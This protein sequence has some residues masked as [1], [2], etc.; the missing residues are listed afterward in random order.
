MNAIRARFIQYF[1]DKAQIIYLAIN[2]TLLNKDCYN[3][4]KVATMKTFPGLLFSFSILETLLTRRC[5][6]YL[7]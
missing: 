5:L 6:K 4:I 1:Q 2:P 7:V 3:N